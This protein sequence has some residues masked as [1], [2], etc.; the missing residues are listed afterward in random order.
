MSYTDG[1]SRGLLDGR[2][3]NIREY[4]A[5]NELKA[6][7]VS[8]VLNTI[9]VSGFF[10]DVSPWERP[11]AT[12]IPLEAEPFMVLC[13]LSINHVKFALEQGRGWIKDIRFYMEHPRHANRLYTRNEWAKLLSE[14]LEERR[15]TRGRIGVD[16]TP[17]SLEHKLK[18]HLPELKVVDASK[19]LRE[20][21]LIKSEEE[22]DI[23]RKGGELTNWAQ[24][25]LK[26]AVEVGKSW[27]E[28]GAEVTYLMAKEAAKRYPNYDITVGAGG[29]GLGP[30]SAMPH[31]PGGYDG[32]KIQKGDVINNGTFASLQRYAVENERTLIVGKPTE[33]QKKLFEVATEAQE[34]AVEMCVAGNRLSDI[35]AAAQGVI[36]KAGYGDC[37]MHRTG[38]GM[39]LGGHEYWDDMPFNHRILKPGMVTSVEPGIYLYGFGGFRHSD[40][41]IIGKDKPEVVTKYTKQL[42]DLIV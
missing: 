20:M 33:E 42:E 31:G 22:L 24:V 38:H 5:E 25:K 13:E 9:Y 15:I 4:L 26:E 10:V 11:I 7:V 37:I 32:R 2:A 23:I 40:T 29:T 30:F 16:T 21:R 1:W 12:V 41:V 8:D 34:R 27:I 17:E 14:T 35:D 18:P 19:L 28:L 6:L 36:E 39:G 3:K